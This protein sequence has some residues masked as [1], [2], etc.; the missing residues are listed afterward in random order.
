MASLVCHSQSIFKV[1]VEGSM[2][3]RKLFLK[4]INAQQNVRFA[5][6]CRLA[7]AFGYSL[8]RVSGRHHLFVRPEATR[9][10]NIQNCQG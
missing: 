6:L 3:L 4:T 1:T 7:L 9:Q 8:N 2:R 10:L 5:D